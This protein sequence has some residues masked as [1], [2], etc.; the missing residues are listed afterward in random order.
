MRIFQIFLL[1]TVIS[2]SLVYAQAP[3]PSRV[4][5]TKIT[6]KKLAQNQSFIG[7][8]YYDRISH[9]ASEVPG[10][11]TKIDF[12]AGDKVNKGTPLVHLNTE[13]LEKEILIRKNQIEQAELNIT[14]SE[15]NYQRMDF[16]YK[17][18]GVS[19]RDYDNARFV[20]QDALLKKQSA[21][22]ILE[23]LLI[24]KKKSIINAPFDGIILEK[25]VDIGDW[26]QQGKQLISIG[27]VKDLFLK[28]PVA[29]TLL[30]F[31]SMDQNVPVTINAYNKEITGTIENLSP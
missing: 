4:V 12:N 20:Y 14:H 2:G 17:K 1:L 11:V 26:A 10:L 29:E 13:I 23:K 9:V 16:L 15:K 19:E 21:K 24:Q 7:T 18:N 5:T 3:P 28:V 6:F 30:E 22:T 31:I 27:S 8:L 25:N